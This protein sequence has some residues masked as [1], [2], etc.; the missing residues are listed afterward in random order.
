MINKWKCGKKTRNILIVYA[1]IF[2]SGLYILFIDYAF[3]NNQI[4]IFEKNLNF[5]NAPNSGVVRG[6]RP[7]VLD[8]I[9]KQ[10]KVRNMREGR[11]Y[12]SKSF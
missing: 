2:A 11:E 7:P 8:L 4:I 5:I 6:N 10:S 3:V 12:K 9:M 1:M